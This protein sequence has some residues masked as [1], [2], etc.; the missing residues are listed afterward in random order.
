MMKVKPFIK[1]VGGKTQLIEQLV[2]Q[3]PVDF[4]NW[5]DFRS[6]G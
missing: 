3:L 6:D 1:L 4:D 2:E 5:E